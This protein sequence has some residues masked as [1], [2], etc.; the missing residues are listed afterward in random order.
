MRNLLKNDL[1]RIIKDKTIIVVLIISV[2]LAFSRPLF[3]ALPGYIYN[4]LYP[5]NPINV[6][7]SAAAFSL[8]LDSFSITGI[9]GLLAPIL[10]SILISKD[11]SFGT[12]RNKIILGYS[13]TK[14]F[15]SYLLSSLICYLI[16]MFGY[17][18]LTLLFS[19]IYFNP[20][21]VDINQ[22]LYVAYMFLKMF[23]Y[24]LVYAFILSFVMWLRI[25]LKGNAS[26]ITLYIVFIF[27]LELLGALTHLISD[28]FIDLGGFG[29]FNIFTFLSNINPIYYIN[30]YL[31]ESK[32]YLS[33]IL[34]ITIPTVLYTSF[35]VF[36]GTLIL[37]KKDIK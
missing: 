27:G 1:L 29:K 10:I 22:G 15:V 21:P 7:E 18:L 4:N 25:S 19:F 8:F 11:I 17:S 13:R 14:I 31:N 36:M 28:L 5:E 2:A 23:F 26:T 16:L 20:F 32:I 35:N 34:W 33:D 37:N 24:I 12:I 6:R 3:N 30:N 9:I